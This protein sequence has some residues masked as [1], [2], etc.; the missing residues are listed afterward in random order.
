MKRDRFDLSFDHSDNTKP[1]AVRRVEVIS[2]PERRRSWSDEEKLEIVSES[3]VEGI[4]VSALARRHGMSPQQLFGWR[5]KI[6]ARMPAAAEPPPS[7]S[8]PAL[9]FVPTV[10][11]DANA[12]PIDRTTTPAASG[13]MTSGAPSTIEIAIGAAVIRITGTV[14]GKTLTAVLRAVKALD[15]H[16]SGRTS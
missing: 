15:V 13:V 12:T 4:N 2:G 16:A 5:A 6:R 10:V 3:L 9:T 1:S 11:S 8:S 7:T 14:D